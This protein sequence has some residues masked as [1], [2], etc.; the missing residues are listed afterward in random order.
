[1]FNI[2]FFFNILEKDVNSESVFLS[3][4]NDSDEIEE[5]YSNKKLAE[6]DI[7]QPKL[8]QVRGNNNFISDKLAATLDR[9]KISDRDTVHIL[10]A[11]AESF[12]V[13]INELII[14]RNLINRIRQY[15]RKNRMEKLRVDFTSSQIDP[16]TIHW[17]GKLLPLLSGKQLVE[18]LPIIISYNGLE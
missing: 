18:H 9:C 4:N 17:D 3:S 16:C 1:L 12:G 10:L 13:N 6:E 14:N 11:T 2:L 15:F 5:T 8:F 7:E